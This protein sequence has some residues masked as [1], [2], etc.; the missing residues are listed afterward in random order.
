[1]STAV[2]LDSKDPQNP[3]CGLR[4]LAGL[5][6]QAIIQ[7]Q[8]TVPDSN[9]EREEIALWAYRMAEEM[10]ATEKRLHLD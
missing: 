6:M 8:P 9:S 5:A 3:E 1:M 2:E 10:V 4:W 7:K